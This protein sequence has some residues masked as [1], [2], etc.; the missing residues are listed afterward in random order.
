L[1]KGKIDR[2]LEMIDTIAVGRRAKA[3]K[4]HRDYF[5]RNVSRLQYE[6]F[7][8][9]NVPIGSG[10][11]ESAIRRIVNIRMKNNGTFWLETNAEG[12]LLLRS[13]VKTDRYDDLVDW[14]LAAAVPWWPCPPNTSTPFGNDL[15]AF[16]A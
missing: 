7:L 8:A 13:Y 1:A 16:M 2:I 14:S 15:D 9:D 4:S 11:V 3:I 5:E 6:D 12:M 10:A